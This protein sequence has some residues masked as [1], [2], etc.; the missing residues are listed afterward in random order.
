MEGRSLPRKLEGTWAPIKYD[1]AD[2]DVAFPQLFLDIHRSVQFR[3][4]KWFASL[5][6]NPE[7]GLPIVVLRRGD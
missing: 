1:P 3:A 2:P 5:G 4:E 7:D 6:S